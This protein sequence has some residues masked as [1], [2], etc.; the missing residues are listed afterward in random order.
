MEHVVYLMGW[1]TGN[2][3]DYDELS[4]STLRFNEDKTITRTDR[5]GIE[6]IY[7]YDE[8]KKTVEEV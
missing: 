5:D 7:R 3:K 8:I 1:I 6:R 2:V 4:G